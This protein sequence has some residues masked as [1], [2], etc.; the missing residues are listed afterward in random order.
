V[1]QSFSEPT[2]GDIRQL[3]DELYRAW[4]PVDDVVMGGRSSSALQWYD[5]IAV[6]TGT[7]SLEQ[8]GGFASVRTA[9]YAPPLDLSAGTGVALRLRGDGR[10]Y[11][12]VLRSG[13]FDTGVAYSAPFDTAAGQWLIVP[14]P[15]ARFVPAFRGRTLADAPP[16]DPTRICALQ[17]MISK[18]E[19]DGQPNRHFLPGPFRLEIDTALA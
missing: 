16:L 4:Y 19:F 18:V 7:V 13:D 11:K 12:L 2:T 17:L 5:R 1:A 6:F 14:L 9:E 10:R 3:T 8:G 15:F